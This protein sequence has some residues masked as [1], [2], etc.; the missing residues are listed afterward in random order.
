MAS[1]TIHLPPDADNITD[2]D[3]FVPVKDGLRALPIVFGP[4]WFLAKRLWWG[5]LGVLVLQGLLIALIWTL[6]LPQPA[7]GLIQAAFN[8]LLG[9]EASSVERW[10]LRRMGWREAGA[11]IAHG[12]EEADARA[13]MLLADLSVTGQL[14]TLPEAP[15]RR[16]VPAIPPAAPTHVLGLFPEARP[17]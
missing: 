9:L 4:L 14:D 2:T 17:R 5:L 16:T 11:V 13:A 12:R 3:R 7:A 15:L 1:W 8:L 10:T 6:P